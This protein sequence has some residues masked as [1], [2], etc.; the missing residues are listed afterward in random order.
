MTGSYCKEGIKLTQEFFKVSS[1]QEKDDPCCNEDECCQ[2]EG[3][4]GENCCNEDGANGHCFCAES[5]PERTK[6]QDAEWDRTFTAQR[7]HRENCKQ[8]TLAHGETWPREKDE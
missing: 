5:C 7:N 3:E 4:C 6:E 8:C 2:G 1:E